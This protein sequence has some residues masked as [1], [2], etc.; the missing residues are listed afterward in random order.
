MRLIKIARLAIG[1]LAAMTAPQALAQ[2][3]RLGPHGL[4][5]PAEGFLRPEWTQRP[6]A[7]QMSQFYPKLPQTFGI[8]G[9]ITLICKATS[10]GTLDA[11]KVAAEKP[12]GLAF[13]DAALLLA[14]YFHFAP[15]HVNGVPVGGD[16]VM[17][18][19][20]FALPPEPPEP[21]L[22][23]AQSAP[24]PQAIAVA[25]KILDAKAVNERLVESVQQQVAIV[26]GQLESQVPDGQLDTPQATMAF[27]ALR[28]ALLA[29]LPAR[30]DRLARAYATDV[31]EGDLNAILAFWSSPAGKAWTLK[32]RTVSKALERSE[33][34]AW[35]V[36][37]R[38]ARQHICEKATCV[39][40][41]A[42]P[43]S[44]TART[45]P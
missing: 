21:P 4:D 32:E 30:L 9:R 1:I 17:L 18:S 28:D 2:S 22:A 10:V 14:P 5:L 26:H 44:S 6:T 8:A 42:V 43:K 37:V 23:S 39:D 7:E 13:G 38:E 24:S 34:E 29:G 25:L 20:K 33:Q 16:D 3:D 31:S 27:D 12:Q 41:D 11:C 45:Q 36:A 35:A 15:K 40:G 19:I